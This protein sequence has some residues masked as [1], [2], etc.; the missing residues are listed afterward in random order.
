MNTLISFFILVF[1][2]GSSVALANQ[3]PS[4]SE[5]YQDKK[6]LIPD[7]W[8]IT[9]TVNVKDDPRVSFESAELSWG[10]PAAGKPYRQVSCNYTSWDRLA[11]LVIRQDARVVSRSATQGSWDDHGMG[12]YAPFITCISRP[13][14]LE[15]CQWFNV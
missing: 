15:D 13:G 3:C 4:V 10:L 14:I 12:D 5:V 2:I 6:W 7:G 1:V 9:N 8:Q 11:Y